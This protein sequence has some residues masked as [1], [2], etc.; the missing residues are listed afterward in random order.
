VH[1]EDQAMAF[2]CPIERVVVEEVT[3]IVSGGSRHDGLKAAAPEMRG[4]RSSR[5][6]RTMTLGSLW[7]DYRAKRQGTRRIGAC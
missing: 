5:Q 6:F 4:N 2:A 3:K 1:E 7:G